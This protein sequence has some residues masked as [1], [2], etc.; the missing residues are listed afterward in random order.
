[1]LHAKFSLP[2]LQENNIVNGDMKTREGEFSLQAPVT[3]GYHFMFLSASKEENA[4]KPDADEY[5]DFSVRVRPFYP[6]YVKPYNYYQTRL[7]SLPE[8]KARQAGNEESQL[9]EVTV[10]ARRGGL[11]GFDK[12]HP[13]LTL[14]AYDTYNQTI[15]AGLSPAWYAGSLSFSLS[16]ARLLIGDM[17]VERS[18]QLERRW[19]GQPRTSNITPSQQYVYNHLQ[20]L[21]SIT[22]YTD[23]APRLEGDPRY[24][25][26]DQPLVTVSLETMPDES[27]RES[28]RDRFYV[29]PGLSVCEAFYQPDYSK[30]ELPKDFKDYRRTLYWNPDL[31][32]DGSGRTIVSFYNN[33]RRNQFNVSAQ[34]ITEKGMILTSGE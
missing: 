28:Y 27:V 7:A 31:R 25:A 17:G 19:N 34:G 21:R 30:K 3:D 16:A 26:S 15:D 8:D 5:P 10:G 20:D 22:V 13:V 12:E 4:F 24:Q 29:M 1:M 11:R 23:Y 33:S 32:L 9:R 14:D 18:Y 6:R 2:V